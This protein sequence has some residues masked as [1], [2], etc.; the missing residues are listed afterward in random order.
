MQSIEWDIIRDMKRITFILVFFSFFLLLPH[1]LIA[2]ILDKT[3]VTVKL[4]T[5]E[6]ISLN[7]MTKQKELIESRTGK[8]MSNEEKSLLLDSAINDVLISQAADNAK[9]SV[10]EKQIDEA[11][12]IQKVALGVPISDEDFQDLI[13]GQTGFSWSEFRSQVKERIKQEQYIVTKYSSDLQ[14]LDEPTEA[15]INKAYEQYATTFTNPALVRAEHIYFDFRDVN[16]ERKQELKAMAEKVA[17]EI[18]SSVTL[19]EQFVKESVDNVAYQGGDLGY[20]IRDEQSTA[21]LGEGF[22]DTVFEMKEETVKGPILSKSGYHVVKVTDK[23]PPKIL[24][25]DDPIFPGEKITVRQRVR[26]V[27]LQQSVQEQFVV[28]V[29][30]EVDFLKKDAK[31]RYI[32]RNW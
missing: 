30:K 8:Q 18:G 32:S 11:I 1:V 5:T 13:L 28:L 3:L 10:T 24:K 6:N 26:D 14:L 23:R 21:I 12:N 17:K 25:L 19:F 16:E 2:Q 9:I 20:I 29:Q 15:E 31:I 7:Q 4:Y 27:L 22:I